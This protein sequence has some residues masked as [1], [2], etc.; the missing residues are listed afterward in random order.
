MIGQYQD[1]DGSWLNCEIVRQ[2]RNNTRIEI[3][4]RPSFLVET[5]KVR[6][7]S[8]TLNCN[9][10]ISGG[11]FGRI[12]PEVPLQRLYKQLRSFKGSKRQVF[13][14]AKG[15][16]TSTGMDSPGAFIA[17]LFGRSVEQMQHYSNEGEGFYPN[18]RQN[19]CREDYPFANALVQT[20][21]DG[22]E[23]LI[24]NAKM[25]L[26]DYEI[27]PLRTT[28]SVR[29]NGKK[30]T[31]KVSGTLDALFAISIDGVTLP[32]IGE[33][34]AK[35]EQV[36]V[37]FAFIQ[38]L[39]NATLLLTKSQFQRLKTVAKTQYEANFASLNCEL[40]RVDVILLVDD[41]SKF[42]SDDVQLALELR[43]HCQKNLQKHLRSI[44]FYKTSNNAT[45]FSIL[46]G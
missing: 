8:E 30:T 39:M 40:P 34:K 42:I 46:E 11:T 35:T 27:Y 10:Q 22:K 18:S 16:L 14:A 19:R 29:E 21:G 36:G 28:N 31:G 43:E 37:T 26:V 2:G 3:P 38:A 23:R 17:E 33:I 12:V 5:K 9:N 20:L 44:G 45:K 32:G 6:L 25:K 4:G 13:E 24:G 15:L 41:R 1:A 7:W